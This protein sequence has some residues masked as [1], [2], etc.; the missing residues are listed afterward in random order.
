MVVS[1]TSPLNYLILIEQIN[2]LPQLYTRVLIPGSVF[3]ELS[4]PE[5]PNL[6]RTWAADLPDWL[7]VSPFVPVPD[8]H[9]NRLHAG[10]RDAI[11]LAL[12]VKADVVIMDERRGREEAEKEPYE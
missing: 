11:S 10:E 12:Q 3:E 4:A 7:K 5:S 2:L 1:D 6:V 8:P 9:L